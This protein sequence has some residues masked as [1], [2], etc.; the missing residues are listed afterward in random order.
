MLIACDSSK[1]VSQDHFAKGKELFE[2]GEYDKAIL[3]LK[4]SNQDGDKRA[5][6]YYYMA[7]LDEKNNNYK[8][9]KENLLKT[10]ELDP[11]NLDARKKLGK[12][13]LLFGELDGVDQQADF[14][15]KSDPT[16]EDA[17]LLKASLL[18]KQKKNEQAQ[19]VLD[20]VL[21]K[22][23]NSVDALSLK[24][25]LAFDANE[26]SKALEIIDLALKI[27]PK[28]LP[29]RIFKI[30]IYAKQNNVDA[31]VD[32]Y[33]QLI[34]IYPD[35][36]KFKLSLASIYSM[37]D[38]LDLAENILREM[39]QK[40]PDKVEPKLI[41]LEFLNAKAK[42]RV[43]FEF[44]KMLSE[45]GLN[46]TAILE[47]S[48]W[49]LASGYI[50]DAT[51][52][53]KKLIEIN[54]ADTNGLT[55]RTLLAE[56]ELNNKDIDSAEK[57][58]KSILEENS[59][60]I[61][62][63]L[64]N[65][66]LLMFKAKPDEAIELL[67]KIVWSKNDSDNAYMLLGQAFS[68]KKDQVQANKNYK[69]ALEVNPA[70]I[71]AFTP[72][73]TEYL[74][75]NQKENARQI[76]IKALTKKPNQINLLTYKAD[77][78][79][80]EKK[81]DDAQ[82]VVQHI[83]LFSKNKD[84]PLYLQANIL[85]GKGKYSEAIKIYEELLIKFPDNINAMINLV[86]AQDALK[87]REKAI[88]YLENLHKNHKDSMAIVGVLSD[89]YIA[90]KDYSKA[91]EILLNQIKVVPSKSV[92]IY[93]ALARIEAILRKDPA[94]AK[95]VYLKGLQDNPENV[96]LLNALASLYDQLGNKDDA[97]KIYEK[98]LDKDPNIA[99][100]KNNLA[101]LLIESDKLEDN[102]QALALSETFKDSDNIYYKDTYAWAL[103]KNGY[104]KEG[105]EILES[106]IL[107]EP[108]VA[109][110]RYHLGVA[111]LNNGNKATALV[112]LKQAISLSEKQNRT[113]VGKDHCAKLI[114][115]LDNH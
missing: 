56:I 62:A 20:E 94:G 81:W 73:Y 69:L 85:Q 52:G 110:I 65:A 68:L 12:V 92:G 59:E 44:D 27:D 84:V 19:A 9:M 42:D 109:E 15:L 71:A 6:T 106:L 105:L 45:I 31:V 98:I 21:T 107:K 38:K 91:K 100:S 70:N 75:A 26:D 30:K 103:V 16:N 11:N 82:E 79:I 74:Q 78:D 28:N 39:V 8:A 41:Y 104:T 93:L 1:E 14:I 64:L 49:M 101:S 58:I 89:I 112:E 114:K 17:K 66:R 111:H 88:A 22:N 34:E 2:R 63:S 83:A 35:A 61:D 99:L 115:E 90:N 55:A 13:S 96:Q 113:F 46:S 23:S 97:R 40:Q 37:T 67:N 54:K 29:L 57:S 60:F 25:A 108:K 43:N 4:T 95:D 87:Q 24:A 33:K 36:V 53:L 86:R 80:S 50:D 77:L 3:E 76:L 102:K 51:K 72:I 7:L 5:E 18:V 32:G 10:I 48:K 47:I